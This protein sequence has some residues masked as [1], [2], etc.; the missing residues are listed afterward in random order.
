MEC[1]D[2][3]LVFWNWVSWLHRFYYVVIDGVSHNSHKSC[4]HGLGRAETIGSF[5][6]FI[7]NDNIKW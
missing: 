6:V 2:I 1:F 7:E 5:Q 4:G 3:G